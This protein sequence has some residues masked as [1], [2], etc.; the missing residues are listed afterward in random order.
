MSK[1]DNNFESCR[2]SQ[3]RIG[4]LL[5]EMKELPEGEGA[6]NQEQLGTIPQ[7]DGFNQPKEF[8]EVSP[9]D[10]NEI[11]RKVA[12]TNIGG[13]NKEHLLGHHHANLKLHV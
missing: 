2:Y 3:M 6:D 8:R 4:P 10:P 11:G 12:S 9:Y 13:N 5:N 1:L 7:W